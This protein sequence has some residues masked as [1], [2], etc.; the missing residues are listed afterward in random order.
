MMA[1]QLSPTPRPNS[2]AREKTGCEADAFVRRTDLG[3]G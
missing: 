1:G 3:D 2:S